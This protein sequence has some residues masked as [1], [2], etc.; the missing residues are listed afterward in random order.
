MP[1]AVLIPGVQGGR[2]AAASPVAS[3]GGVSSVHAGRKYGFEE[4]TTD[5]GALLADPDVDA[6]VIATR[7]DS[8]ADLCLQGAGSRQARVRREAAG[9]DPRGT[10]S[11]R[12]R[13]ADGV[14][15]GSPC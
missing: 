10:G 7:H 2:R 9:P 13:F 15:S 12:G 3:S 6:V 5:A 8:H 1:T 14:R 4:A 11:D